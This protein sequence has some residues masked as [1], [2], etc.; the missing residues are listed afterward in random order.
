ML[1]PDTVKISLVDDHTLFRKGMVELINGFPGFYVVSEADNGQDFIKQFDINEIPDIVLLDITM[2]KMTGH[3]TALWLKEHHPDIKVLALS[4]SDDEKDIIKMLQSGARGYILK[5]AEPYE[6]RSALNELVKKDFY[7]SELVS[8]TLIK[9]IHKGGDQEN[10]GAVQLNDR[11]I[12]FLKL[13]SSELTYKE[14]ADKMCVAPRTVDGYREALFEKLNV[15]SRTGLVLYAIK[16]E[17]V[18]II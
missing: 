1:D 18:K 3:Q 10:I 12:T 11:E 16:H 13:A 6:L 15:K 14:I 9:N 4:M 17:I 5:D 2:P 8:G 7:Y